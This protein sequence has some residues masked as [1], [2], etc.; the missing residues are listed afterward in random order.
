MLILKFFRIKIN[1]KKYEI[2]MS[3]NNGI[4]SVIRSFL[5]K[6]HSLS[7]YNKY[8]NDSF[9]KNVT[10]FFL[11]TLNMNILHLYFVADSLLENNII[12]ITKK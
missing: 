4:I 6:V 1:S 2:V 9:P 12:E 8:P 10:S 7:D 5:Q 11:I 3:K